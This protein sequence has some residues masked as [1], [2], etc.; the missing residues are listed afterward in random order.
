[1][2]TPEQSRA[3]R[4]WLDWTQQTLAERSRVALSTVRDFEK[5]RRV[6]IANNLYAMRQALEHAGVRFVFE[7]KEATGIAIA[8]ARGQSDQLSA[9]DCASDR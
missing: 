3:A 2:L 5:G 6:P 9:E 4:G 8:N 1:M 7:G